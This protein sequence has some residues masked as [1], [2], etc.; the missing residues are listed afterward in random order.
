M[1]GYII[2]PNRP[3]TSDEG[4]TLYHLGLAE[5]AAITRGSESSAGGKGQNGSAAGFDYFSWLF[6]PFHGINVGTILLLNI[7]FH[8]MGRISN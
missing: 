4:R 2:E 7:T 5:D 1:F 6:E 3:N 8:C